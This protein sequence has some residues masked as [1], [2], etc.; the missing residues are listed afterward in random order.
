MKDKVIQARWEVVK[1]EMRE[2]LVQFARD[3]QT[4]TYSELARMLQT[5]HMHYHSHIFFRLL[6]ELGNE[7]EAEERPC[8][9]ALVVTK[10]TGMP[11]GGF[12]ADIDTELSQEP[13]ALETYWRT[14]L[15]EVFDYYA[16]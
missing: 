7:E 1:D 11:G 12:F 9:P 16:G 5:V 6:I 8:L 10:H 3:K 4:V 2:I 13:D 15:E 14:R